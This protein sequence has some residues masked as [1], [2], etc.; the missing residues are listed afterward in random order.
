MKNRVKGRPL[1]LAA[2][3]AAVAVAMVG[4]GGASAAM[5]APTAD[6][7][8]AVTVSPSLQ[9]P[10]QQ[11]GNPDAV[12]AG[13][14]VDVGFAFTVPS[15]AIAGDTATLTLP[16]ELS[17]A[18]L[19]AFDIVAEDGASIGTVAPNGDAVVVTLSDYI[20]T[21]T[22]IT[23]SVDFDARFDSPSL[24]ATPSTV[25]LA[26]T[27][28]DAT[29]DSSLTGYRVTDNGFD[30][31]GVVD[32][33]ISGTTL[34]WTYRV[35]APT[36]ELDFAFMDGATSVDCAALQVTYRDAVWNEGDPYPSEAAF[37]AAAP[38]ITAT[39]GAVSSG[40]ESA[41]QV[42][43]LTNAAAVPSG[44]MREY[45]VVTSITDA[46]QAQFQTVLA[47]S[48]AATEGV[49]YA[50]GFADRQVSDGAG[51]G[52]DSGAEPITPT[53]PADNTGT[54]VVGP[55]VHTGGSLQDG[56]PSGWLIAG[57]ALLALAGVGAG[58]VG[59]RRFR[60]SHQAD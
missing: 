14:L 36:Y 4:F 22:G 46:Q 59:F 17:V 25:P 24:T 16:S 12:P 21:H 29:F 54:A 15:D 18:D 8:D 1:A 11:T 10:W 60:S 53:D 19:S 2:Q 9:T 40:L 43:S 34:T 42:V 27:T 5:A 6:F 41:T 35:A 58:A 7:F 32:G 55:S 56:S 44:V 49:L 33:V 39:C 26:F 13:S 23:G 31:F 45:R 50:A 57:A 28:D 47:T 37:G 48:D 3:T 30:A 20:T 52:V 51:A 38:A